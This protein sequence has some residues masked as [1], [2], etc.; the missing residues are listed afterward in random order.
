MAERA[1]SEREAEQAGKDAGA[2]VTSVPRASSGI[3]VSTMPQS[4]VTR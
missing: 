1:K 2:S 3:A 4:I